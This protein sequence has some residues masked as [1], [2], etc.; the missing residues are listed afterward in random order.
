[1]NNNQRFNVSEEL[2]VFHKDSLRKNNS[3]R[4]VTLNILLLSI[5]FLFSSCTDKDK[6]EK[7]I[8]LPEVETG[9]S[10]VFVASASV[11]C[12]GIV[13]SDGGSNVCE[14]GICYVIGDGV[15]TL[16][17][18][19]VSG[20]SGQGAYTC[21]FDL[22]EDGE[23]S[24]RAY[25]TNEVGTSFGG[26]KTFSYSSSPSTS[27]KVKFGD[28]VW[29]D[30]TPSVSLTHHLSDFRMSLWDK[31]GDK[32]ASLSIDACYGV[33]NGSIV[34]T[35]VIVARAAGQP[36]YNIESNNYNGPTCEFNYPYNDEDFHNYFYINLMATVNHQVWIPKSFTINVIE[37]NSTQK[38]CSVT[39]NAVMIKRLDL[40]NPDYTANY[41]NTAETKTLSI[42]AYNIPMEIE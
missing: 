3:Q 30:D 10:T 6:N 42:E 13:T 36:I 31:T 40:K 37:L 4:M 25:A 18:K 41:I 28:D 19:I 7:V 32:D 23:Y 12:E 14:R 5:M 29:Y 17:D 26:V 2:S 35:T 15:P 20:G 1:M 21:S 8:S 27:V 24:Y 16:S 34:P 33:I 22:S 39:A 9:E 38:I 11:T